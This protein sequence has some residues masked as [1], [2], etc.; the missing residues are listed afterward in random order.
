MTTYH[1]P[2]GYVVIIPGT[3][4][5]AENRADGLLHDLDGN[6]VPA[7]SLDGIEL[8]HLSSGPKGLLEPFTA[9][10]AVGRV[11]FG[12]GAMANVYSVEVMN[13]LPQAQ[14]AQAAAEA[15]MARAFPVSNVGL[16]PDG[17]PY[18]STEPVA[19]GGTFV[20]NQDGSVDAV[21]PY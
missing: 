13:A 7:Y 4:E 6:A 8:A 10:I 19:V 21:F 11:S 12:D 17:V 2:V 9:S 18:V 20:I 14:A 1:Y 5:V 15:A 3:D 16:D